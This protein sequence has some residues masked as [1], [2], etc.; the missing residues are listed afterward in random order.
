MCEVFVTFWDLR[1]LSGGEGIEFG[2]GDV[3]DED[4]GDK[5]AFLNAP[6]HRDRDRITRPSWGGPAKRCR[7]AWHGLDARARLGGHGGALNGA[8]IA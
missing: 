1:S 4:K 5:V 3:I 6:S 2:F 8:W 7:V